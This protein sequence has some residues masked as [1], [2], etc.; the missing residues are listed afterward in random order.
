MGRWFFVAMAV[1]L[2]LW[3]GCSALF[4]AGHVVLSLIA[5]VVSHPIA[6]A[7]GYA[8]AGCDAR[9]EAGRE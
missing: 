4:L 7:V 9:R 3:A 6:W 5:M 2:G 1:V 8:A